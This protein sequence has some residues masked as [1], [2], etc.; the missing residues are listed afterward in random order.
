MVVSGVFKEPCIRRGVDP[1]GKGQF[2]GGIFCTHWKSVC[3]QCFKTVGL[4]S[5]RASGL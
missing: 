3:L 5:G 1:Q 2:L 4:V